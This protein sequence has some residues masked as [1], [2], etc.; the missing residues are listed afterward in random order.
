MR[1]FLLESLRLCVVFVR[2]VGLNMGRTGQRTRKR[3]F[4]GNQHSERPTKAQRCDLKDS[5]SK[6]QNTNN[7]SASQKKIEAKVEVKEEKNAYSNLTGYRFMDMEILATVFSLMQCDNCGESNIQLSEISFQRHGCA[8]CL[9]VLCMSCGWK[10]TFYTSK[11]VSRYYEVNRRLVYGMRTMGQGQASARRFCGIMNMPPAPKPRAYSKHNQALLKATKAVASS[12]LHEAGKEIHRLKGENC[13][14]FVNCGVSCDGTWQKRGHSSLNG[15]VA[16]LSIDTGKCLDVE[17]LTKVCRGCQRHEVNSDPL[18]EEEWHLQHARKCKANYTGSAP[19]MET[20]GVKRIFQRSE[21]KHNLCFAEY[22]G[23]GDSKGF[24]KG[25]NTYVDRGLKVVKK[26]C[27]GHV[28]K[29]VGTALRKL[30]KEKKGLAGRGKLTDTMIDRLQN[31]YGIAI[32]SNVGNLL[33]M[34][35]AIHASLMHCASSKERNLHHH[36]PEGAD[37]WCRFN[38]DIANKTKLFKPGAGLPLNVIVELKPIYQRL[39]EDTLLSRCL[40]GKTQ[41]QNE[42]LN[43]MIWDR[44]PKGVF[45]GSDVLELGV[46][47]A[48]A[49]FNIGTQAALNVLTE[50]GIEPGQHCSEEM[51]RT[52]RIRVS[53][54]DYK[55]KESSRKRR[56]VLRARLK[57]KGDQAKEK[58]GVTYASGA[59]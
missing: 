30:K 32:C 40:D 47:D 56:K 43:A 16:V 26:E 39:S 17:V 33:G 34:K 7:Q 52:D 57:N 41:N 35:K 42:S 15:C 4:Q 12:T 27:V 44:V 28:Q 31:Y 9:R 46:C 21:D 3:K 5:E 6:F 55:V 54:A 48:V 37:S 36:C 25:E 1:I 8:S 14:E 22:Y 49:H 13:S 58:E 2:F 50:C 18:A 51:R 59:F 24:N 11:K 20:E 19:A 45:V 10:H 38:K 29:R 23:D 53:K